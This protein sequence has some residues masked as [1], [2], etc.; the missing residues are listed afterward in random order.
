MFGLKRKYKVKYMIKNTDNGRI[1]D[2]TE[3]LTEEEIEELRAKD[4]ITI[5]SVEGK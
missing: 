1:D 5:M 3:R 4:N 2:Y